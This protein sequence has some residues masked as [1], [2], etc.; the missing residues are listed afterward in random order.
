MEWLLVTEK[1]PE[2]MQDVLLFDGK[3]FTTGYYF[4]ATKCFIRYSDGLRLSGVLF[5]TP[6]PDVTLS[7]LYRKSRDL[8]LMESTPRS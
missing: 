2:E 6:I 8:N 1:L 3:G 7:E 4:S 5:W